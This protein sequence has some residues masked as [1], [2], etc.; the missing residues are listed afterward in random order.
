ME[1][2]TQEMMCQEKLSFNN[3]RGAQVAAITV[4]AQQSDVQGRE[5][6][7]RSLDEPAVDGF[8]GLAGTVCHSCQAK[9]L[10]NAAAG[11]AL[12]APVRA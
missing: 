4:L 8:S 11:P 5:V 10:A 3:T 12:R 1:S 9:V 2:S 7:L 6:A